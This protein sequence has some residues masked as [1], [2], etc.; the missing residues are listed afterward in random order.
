V[1]NNL[2][3]R[4]RNLIE[5][6][7]DCQLA[8]TPQ[9]FYRKWSVNHEQIA[10]IC[11][12]SKGTVDRWFSQGGNK[13]YPTSNDLRHLALMDFLLEH[14]EDIPPQLKDLLCPPHR[15]V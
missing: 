8:M 13:H 12:R 4:E 14:Y 1:R 7:S 3:Q 11:K 9:H 10:V 15:D 2:T 5:L 6:Y